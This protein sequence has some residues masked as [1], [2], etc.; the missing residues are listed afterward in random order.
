MSCKMETFAT[1]YL[2]SNCPLRFS[3]ATSYIAKVILL[4]TLVWVAAFST[5]T[6]ANDWPHWR[7]PQRNG[8]VDDASGFQDGKPWPGPALWQLEI[9]EGASAPVVIGDRIYAMGWEGGQDH[10]VALDASTGKEVWTVSY[11]SPRYGRLATGD[12]GLYS[13]PTSA[14]E[15]DPDSQL[16]FTLSCDGSLR[17]WDTEGELQ[18]HHELHEEFSVLQRPKVGRSGHRDYGFTTSPC[19]WNDWLIV[20]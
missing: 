13:G 15:F 2:M 7:G 11:T 18:W 3:T 20:V 19:V 10:L 17:A 14:I 9:G 16:L 1:S 8:L 12:Q 4:L 5:E 6:H